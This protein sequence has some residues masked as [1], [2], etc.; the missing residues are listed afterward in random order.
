M[1]RIEKKCLL[2][3]LSDKIKVSAFLYMVDFSHTKADEVADVRKQLAAL[4]AQFH[5]VKNTLMQK[6][7]AELSWPSFPHLL[8]G[9]TGIVF[10]GDNPTGVAKCLVRFAKEKEKFSPKGGMLDGQLYDV[11]AL[12]SLSEL[13]DLP[14]LRATLLSLLH[15]PY[16]QCLCAMQGVPQSLLNVLQGYCKRCKQ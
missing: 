15:A 3:E 13:P 10:G 16:R 11:V 1:M 5:V 6:I 14:T 4:G 8:K 2:S 9:Q 12:E 7:G